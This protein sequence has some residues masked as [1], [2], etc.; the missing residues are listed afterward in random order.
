M[1]EETIDRLASSLPEDPSIEA[2]G[3]SSNP[4]PHESSEGDIDIFVYCSRIP[5]PSFRM[6]SY[7]PEMK[8]PDFR[9]RIFVDDIW[10]DADFA[11][12]GDVDAWIMYFLAEDA[13]KDFDETISG[14]NIQRDNGFYP[15]GR[16]AMFR[17]MTILYD[18]DNFLGGLKRRLETYPG[19]M[20]ERIRRNC[21]EQMYDEEDL[22]RA[23]TRED[24]LFFHIAIDDALDALMQYLFAVNGELF[25][26]RKRNIDMAAGFGKAPADLT[27]RIKRI[28]RLGSDGQELPRAFAE[29][30]KLRDETVSIGGFAD[31]RIAPRRDDPEGVP[32]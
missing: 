12:I 22:V 25:P 24:V 9:P 28:I 31:D 17:K 5:E 30:R 32:P 18:K 8:G 10:G 20:G 14:R 1:I 11:K 15:S 19:Q 27:S 13:R 2:I 23:S 16:L 21:V 4:I 29:Y 7:P 6:E 3:L 26:G